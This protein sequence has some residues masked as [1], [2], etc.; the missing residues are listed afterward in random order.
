M[1]NQA[2]I[3]IGET[4][5][6]PWKK[7]DKAKVYLSNKGQIMVNELMIPDN[8]RRDCR[9]KFKFLKEYLEKKRLPYDVSKFLRK[10]LRDIVFEMGKKKQKT[11]S[12]GKLY[13]ISH[14]QNW[15]AGIRKE[16]FERI[17]GFV[18]RKYRRELWT[19]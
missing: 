3:Y 11:I 5:L 1:N 16:I 12:F 10:E 4:H 6:H 8:R 18:R 9:D 15:I 2:L 19:R 7:I 14:N 17:A 13:D